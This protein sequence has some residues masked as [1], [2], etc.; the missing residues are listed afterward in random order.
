MGSPEPPTS[1]RVVLDVIERIARREGV[2]PLDLTPP[3]YDAVDPDALEAL[4]S[5]PSRVQSV[6]FEYRTWSV[7][8]HPDADID[9]FPLFARS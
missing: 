8:I 3:L 7:I 4:L 1:Q 5:P 9:I 2:D 6:R